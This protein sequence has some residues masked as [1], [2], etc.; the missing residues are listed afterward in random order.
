MKILSGTV[1]DGRIVVDDETL[2]EGEKVTVLAR[3]NE[4]SFEVS[5]DEK[6]ILLE[7]LA[8]AARGDFVDSDQLL[9][10]LDEPG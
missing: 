2:P 10:E 4:E 5:A 6:R 9:R 3:E 8:Q 1:H 7:S